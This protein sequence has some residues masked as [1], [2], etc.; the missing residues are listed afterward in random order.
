VVIEG[1][2]YILPSLNVAMKGSNVVLFLLFLSFISFVTA[3]NCRGYTCGQWS[4]CSNNEKTRSCE[5]SYYRGDNCG[6]TQ[7]PATTLPCDIMTSNLACKDSDTPSEF[8][9][10]GWYGEEHYLKGHLINEAQNADYWDTC[11]NLFV[12]DLSRGFTPSEKGNILVE[13]S[14]NA[15]NFQYRAIECPL[16]CIDG[17]CVN[18]CA[19]TD[20]END[21]LVRGMAYID[22]TGK[23]IIPDEAKFTTDSCEGEF[24]LRQ[25]SCKKESVGISSSVVDCVFGCSEG[26]CLTI[27]PQAGEVIDIQDKIGPNE[28]PKST[29]QKYCSGCFLDNKCY[30]WGYRKDRKFCSDAE[31]EFVIQNDEEAQCQNNFECSSNV[32]ISGTCVSEGLFKKFLNWLGKFFG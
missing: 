9:P 18:P 6:N 20:A 14:C 1:T 25:Y 11:T 21:P 3:E 7:E 17:E 5:V 23:N 19:D 29:L 16:G 27:A 8:D 28:V 31:E 12:R 2:F 22:Y 10:K 4:E 24:M 30:S 32:C 15:D 26:A 13:Y